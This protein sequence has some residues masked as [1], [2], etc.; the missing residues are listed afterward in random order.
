M[1]TTV[2]R[3]EALDAAD[4]VAEGLATPAQAWP[5]GRPSGGRSWPQSLGGGAAGIA[6]LHIERAR[7][8]HADWRTA[9]TWLATAVKDE[10]S[11]AAN[12]NLYF[13]APALAFV[14]HLAD[15]ATHRY[16]TVLTHLDDAT[17]K[18]THARLREAHARLDRG[19]RPLMAD[20]DQIRGLSGLG[21][22]HLSR[23]PDHPVTR[24][25]L[26]YLVRLTHTT[27]PDG[28][29]LPPWWTSVAPN[30]E[31]SSRYPHGHGNVGLSHGIGSALTLM[32][33]ALQHEVTVPGLTE[34]IVTVCAWTDQWQQGTDNAPWWP[35]FLT[36]ENALRTEPPAQP[37]PS[38]CYGVTGTARAQQLAGLA[39]NEPARVH[40]AESALLAVL[41]DAD[42]LARLPE[43][44]LCHGIA[45]LLHTARRM[46]DQTQNPEI[47]AELP[48][49]AHQLVTAL[50]AP[51]LDPEFLD[52]AAGAALALHS[53]GVQHIPAPH[54]DTCL[55]LA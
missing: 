40:T 8:G 5:G 48:R 37:R 27:L 7:T 39:L 26:S 32:S 46:A 28:R 19:E 11:A 41:R 14:V 24:D 16:G 42:Q 44:G 22:Y 18:V 9:H 34:A 54:W 23:H 33:L 6:V 20:F 29:G 31:P 3:S 13:G 2:T 47:A 30:G 51:G 25:V 12:A 49:L 4:R 53:L 10:I 43:V 1:T 45:G 36:I 35:G 38:W 21:A 52:G 17:E 50:E 15:S 55:A